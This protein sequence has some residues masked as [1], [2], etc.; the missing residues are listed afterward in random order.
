MDS[1]PEYG[2]ALPAMPA[3]KTSF[4]RPAG[5]LPRARLP[6]TEPTLKVSRD[7]ERPVGVGLPAGPTSVMSRAAPHDATCPSALASRDPLGKRPVGDGYVVAIHPNLID[8]RLWP[9]D[10]QDL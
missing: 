1:Y 8:K 7:A 2:I 9:C 3:S 10:L 6:S 5:C 4:P